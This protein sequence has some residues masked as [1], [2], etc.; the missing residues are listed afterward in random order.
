MTPEGALTTLHSFGA[1]QG[2]G[3]SPSGG[4][5]QGTDGSFYGTTAA[6]GS[7]FR[8]TPAGALTTL[9]TF[10]SQPNCTDGSYPFA[11]LVQ[12]ADGNFY[13]TTSSGGASNFGTVF[14]I[15]PAGTLTTLHSF[16]ANNYPCLDGSNPSAGLVEATDGNFYGTS[17]GGAYNNGNVF[18]I[19]PEGSL[20]ILYN[21]CAESNCE[22][23]ARP[24]A[25]LVQGKD[26]NFYGTTDQGGAYNGG[27]VF[28]ITPEGALTSLHSF[29]AEANC[30][31]GQNPRGLIQGTDGNIYGTTVPIFFSLGTVFSLALVPAPIANVSAQS[32]TFGNWAQGSTSGSEGVTL[33]N[34]GTTPM[35]FSGVTFTGADAGDFA[36]TN[37]CPTSLARGASCEIRVTFSPSF[38]GAETATL[39]INDNAPNTPQSVA[40]S[41]AGSV[42]VILGPTSGNFGNVA[43]GTLSRTANITL[44]NPQSV[45]L[46]ISSIT[47]SNPDFAETN[48]C[49][50]SLAPHS[51]CT[52][53]VILTP[54][55][56]GAETATLTVNDSAT[57]TPQTVALTGAGH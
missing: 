38:L 24:K 19:T 23:G 1:Q 36:E 5:V 41:G 43:R 34:T 48:T 27:T 21:F 45:A 11:G 39:N 3:A 32:L 44:A 40:L 50:A 47:L 54:S 22:D 12:G 4:L 8:I 37:T 49:G 7:I 53:S 57:N 10:C 16:C 31:D 29:C 20:T 13:G 14:V 56:V 46:S 9:Y 42:P 35:T 17:L 30:R 25:A 52:I 51:M 2:D 28:K 55:I 6:G 15:T 18:K 33:T 26:G